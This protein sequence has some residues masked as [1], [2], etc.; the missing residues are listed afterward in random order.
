LD[1]YSPLLCIAQ[2][3]EYAGD[4][5]YTTAGAYYYVESADAQE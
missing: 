1:E 4:D 2:E 3:M 5:Y